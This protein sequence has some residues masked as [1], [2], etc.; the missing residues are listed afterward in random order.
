MPDRTQDPQ[1]DTGGTP[2]RT[3][4]PNHAAAFVTAPDGSTVR[5]L[6]ATTR[7][8]LAEFRLPPGAIARA[9]AHRTVEEVWLVLSGAGRLWRRSAGREEVV[10]L[11]PGVSLT[12]PTGVHFQFRCES[13]APLLIVAVTMPP[14]PGAEEAIAV[15]GPWPPTL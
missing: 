8:G 2:W 14:W 1:R 10:A 5:P 7:G 6:A 4:A 9:V 12:I 11:T 13:A 3:L 15:A